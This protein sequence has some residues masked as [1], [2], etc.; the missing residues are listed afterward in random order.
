MCIKKLLLKS[1]LLIFFPLQG[2]AEV[3]FKK[4]LAVQSDMEQGTSVST[5]ERWLQPNVPSVV[6]D[7]NEGKKVATIE[8]KSESNILLDNIEQ[9]QNTTSLSFCYAMYQQQ[10]PLTAD[11][12]Y[13]NSL[14]CFRQIASQ[15]Q[16]VAQLIVGYLMG[17][18]DKQHLV[19]A[20]EWLDKGA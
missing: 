3:V 19:Q 13:T 1:L 7:K 15:K 10:L 2:S 14:N 8:Q 6:Q 17:I 5:E 16:G 4:P 20:E 11:S 12:D 9:P 18:A